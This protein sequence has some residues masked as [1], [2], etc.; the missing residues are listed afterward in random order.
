MILL[1][2]ILVTDCAVGFLWVS[3]RKNRH[4]GFIAHLYV[5]RYKVAAFNRFSV[6]ARIIITTGHTG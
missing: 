1:I 4:F 2:Y 5:A 6:G 3:T